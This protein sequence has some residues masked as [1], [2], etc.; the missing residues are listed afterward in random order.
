ML[1][2]L[3]HYRFI[4]RSIDKTLLYFD[5]ILFEYIDLRLIASLAT[6]HKN[7]VNCLTVTISL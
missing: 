2:I 4:F 3:A 5:H 6:A 7:H 1:Q